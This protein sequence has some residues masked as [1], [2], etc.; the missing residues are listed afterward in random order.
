MYNLEL[1]FMVIA[2]IIIIPI[3]Y[4]YA[5]ISAKLQMIQEENVELDGK[6]ENYKESEIEQV[7]KIQTLQDEINALN[8]IIAEQ[9]KSQDEAFT[10]AKATL[11]DLGNNLSKQLL[12]LHKQ[13][14]KEAQEVSDKTIKQ[15]NE[16]FQ[17]EMERLVG[18]VNVLS[19]EV[20]QSRSAVDVIKKSLLSPS[21]A[22][23]LAEITLENILKSSG[24]RE[25]VDF[26]VQRNVMAEKTIRPDAVIFLPSDN[27]MLID[28]KSSKFLCEFG[29]YSS[30]EEKKHLQNKLMQTM[31]L[32]LKDLVRKEYHEHFQQSMNGKN[33]KCNNIITLMFLPTESAL[34]R[35][36][37]IDPNFIQNAWSHNIYP[38]GPA[39]LMNILSF[40]RFQINDYMRIENHKVIIEEVKKLINAV[41]HLSEHSQKIGKNIQSLANNYDKFSASFNRNFLSKAKNIQTLG[42]DV[43]KVKINPLERYHLISAAIDETKGNEDS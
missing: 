3:V 12:E 6:V 20:Q 34:E 31:Q 27:Y 1:I 38:V 29:E 37:N 23:K 8:K 28:A 9:K 24:L 19:K 16:K 21:G 18:M 7:K 32:H 35:I 11:V 2:V 33:Q 43:G 41:G 14:S 17:N 26:D 25:H 5:G 42:V 13:E 30:D 15:T 10:A 40:A 22:G 36:T 4:K 39:G